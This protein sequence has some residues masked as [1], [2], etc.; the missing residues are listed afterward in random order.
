MVYYTY[1]KCI[2]S[3]SLS[4]QVSAEPN[5]DEVDGL[6][7][8]LQERDAVIESL[9][10][11]QLLSQDENTQLKEQLREEREHTKQVEEKLKENI[12]K[13]QEDSAL[14]KERHESEK[15]QLSVELQHLKGRL[16]GINRSQ[17]CTREHA[18]SLEKTLAQKETQL[19]QLS[20]EN[21]RI[22]AQKEDHISELQCALNE[23]RDGEANLKS[24]LEKALNDGL[25]NKQRGDEME[26]QVEEVR[27][28]L[29]ELKRNT[30]TGNSV[31]ELEEQID[32]LEQ[33]KTDLQVTSSLF[34][35]LSLF[36]SNLCI[37][38]VCICVSFLFI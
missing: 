37:Q 22:L 30:L 33:V 34:P 24:E 23:L 12:R 16:A 36:L 13:S 4:I 1:I 20:T 15:H 35:T 29:N 28:E 7:G 26:R 11:D 5:R 2:I 19:Q 27:V 18:N 8:A 31:K 14:D 38:R 25:L 3:Y 6:Q 17:Q 10:Q 9:K 32:M 21:D